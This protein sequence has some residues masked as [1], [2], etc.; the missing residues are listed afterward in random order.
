MP[1]NATIAKSLRAGHRS[2]DWFPLVVFFEWADGQ[3]R[4]PR[5]MSIDRLRKRLRLSDRDMESLFRT[6]EINGL[7]K[8]PAGHRNR[9]TRI[10]WAFTLRGVVDVAKGK[11]RILERIDEKRRVSEA[12]V[13]PR[14]LQR[15][16]SP[17]LFDSRPRAARPVVGFAE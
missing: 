12:R 3:R 4:S 7:V 13:H 2:A 5:T 8:T 14:N 11:T 10:R 17:L 6:F 16:H 15:R 9:I 1:T